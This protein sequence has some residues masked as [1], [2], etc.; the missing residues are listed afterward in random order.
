VHPHAHPGS[1][2]ALRAGP[3]GHTRVHRFRVAAPR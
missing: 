3:G 2:M 1:R